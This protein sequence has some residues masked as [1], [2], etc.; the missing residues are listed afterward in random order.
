[1]KQKGFTLLELLVV[2]SIVGLLGTLAMVALGNARSQARDTKRKFEL[3][4]LSIAMELYRDNNNG[5]LPI[6]DYTTS[7]DASWDTLLPNELPIM[8]KDPLNGDVYDSSASDPLDKYFYYYI[9]E[10][11]ALSPD[12]AVVAPLEN[13]IGTPP[14]CNG[15]PLSGFQYAGNS[16]NCQDL[17]V[18][19]TGT[20]AYGSNAWICIRF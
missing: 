5:S 6:I 9:S 18:G 3:K 14:V 7:V 17:D 10:G 12:Y 19:C 16:S 1:M 8:P 11:T 4:Q 2:I 13:P 15:P 20:G